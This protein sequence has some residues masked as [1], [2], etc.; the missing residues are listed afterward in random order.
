MVVLAIPTCFMFNS[1][2]TKVFLYEIIGTHLIRSGTLLKADL[3]YQTQTYK[4]VYK[5]FKQTSSIMYTTCGHFSG[6][7]LDIN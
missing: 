1:F 3:S 5:T 2:V 7:K 4:S 6:L